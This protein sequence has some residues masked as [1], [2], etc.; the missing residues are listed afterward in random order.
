M[1]DR[2][3]YKKGIKLI[4]FGIAGQQVKQMEQHKA[5]TLRYSPPEL[6][7]GSS[8]EADPK[9]D[10]WSLGVLL[11]RLIFGKFPFNAKQNKE[12]KKEILEKEIEFP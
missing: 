4:D 12:L 1:Q 5:G 7:S 10:V 8:Y 2:C 6:V 9:F 3:D 11:F